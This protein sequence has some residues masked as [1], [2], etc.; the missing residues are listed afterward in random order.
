MAFP[1]SIG[2]QALLFA[3]FASLT[4]ILSVIIEPTYDNLLVPE[5]DAASLY[6]SLTASGGTSF[7]SLGA[8]LSAFVLANLVDPAIALVGL[9]VG[10]AYLGRS[11]LGRW[12]TNAEP[13]LGRLVLA[14]IVANFS[15]PIAG[16]VLGLAGAT[17]PVIAGFDH[18]AWR[19]WMNLAGPGGISFSWDNGA[20][21]F[22]VTFAMFSVVLLLA[23]AVALRD[24]LLAV[25]LVL[26]PMFTI[27][28]PIP[29]LAPLARRA[30]LMFGE[31][32]FLPCVL[33][34]P[35]ELAVGSSSVLLL[36]GYLTVAL[37]SPA[38]VSLA[39]AQL[40]QSGFP[41]AGGVIANGFQRGLGVASSATETALR[42]AGG[43]LKG[44]ST[45]GQVAGA[46][47]RAFG[48]SVFPAALPLL[49]ADALG[50]GAAQLLRHIPAGR[51]S[52][53]S[54]DRF[55]ATP[56]PVAGGIRRG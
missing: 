39:G 11:V 49:G 55:P 46:A 18:G 24:A 42:P 56:L 43:L 33:V 35:L 14:V 28:W 47:G 17:Y 21:A 16:A 34:I 5:L 22:V 51:F 29:T 48:G 44:S 38:L 25:L 10:L 32:A 4:A 45:A 27:L 1:Q 12:G 31:L 23:A 50:R 7:L 40:T 52:G 15:L 20:L 13:L 53:T 26:L 41:S 36:L 2:V 3:L 8:S 9:A 37:A 30:W 19:T 6:P 54:Q